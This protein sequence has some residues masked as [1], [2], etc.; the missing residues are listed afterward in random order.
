MGGSTSTPTIVEFAK[1]CKYNKDDFNKKIDV[2][3]D[4]HA[5]M[6]YYTE[7]LL[8]EKMP[9]NLPE[10]KNYNDISEE[11]FNT[12]RKEEMGDLQAINPKV[13]NYYDFFNALSNLQAEYERNDITENERRNKIRNI[14][15]ISYIVLKLL[16]EDLWNSCDVQQI[17]VSQK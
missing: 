14:F 1:I 12:R 2:L 16:V 8:N 15:N 10:Y 11:Y 9:I 3:R 4:A 5:L 6:Q 7:L 13:R 17:P